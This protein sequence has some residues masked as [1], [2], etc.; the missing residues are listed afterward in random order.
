MENERNIS[1]G[2][3]IIL[4]ALLAQKYMKEQKVRVRKCHFGRFN[5]KPFSDSTVILHCTKRDKKCEIGQW[6]LL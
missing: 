2:G 3:T 5:S 1:L 6:R 4:L